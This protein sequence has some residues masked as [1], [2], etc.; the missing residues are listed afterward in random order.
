MVAKR[1]FW[2]FALAVAGF[3][4]GIYVATGREHNGIRA[5]ILC[6]PAVLM[7]FGQTDPRQSDFW[8]LIAPLNAALYPALGSQAGRSK[9]AK[10]AESQF[11]QTSTTPAEQLRTLVDVI[12]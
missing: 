6:P 10:R 3:L 5:L 8:M 9:R 11:Q 4:A 12:S 7:V 1:V 2:I